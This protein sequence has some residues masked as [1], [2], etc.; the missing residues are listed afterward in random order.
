MEML[1]R[2]NNVAQLT[3]RV[4]LLLLEK[5]CTH[6]MSRKTSSSRTHLMLC[7]FRGDNYCMVLFYS[8]Q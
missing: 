1:S 6:K 4:A 2:E 3:Q 8:R 7:K 5:S